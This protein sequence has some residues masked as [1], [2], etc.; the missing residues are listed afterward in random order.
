MTTTAEW[1][2]WVRDLPATVRGP[3][4][5]ILFALASRADSTGESHS[6]VADLCRISGLG[7]T[8]V[9]TAMRE[10]EAMGV[11]K[12]NRSKGGRTNRYRL[13]QTEPVVSR[14]VVRQPVASRPKTGRLATLDR[15][16]DDPRPVASR[17]LSRQE[18]NKKQNKK[19]AREDEQPTEH[20]SWS[21]INAVLM[22]GGFSFSFA[23]P[24]DK[25]AELM[26][27]LRDVCI[28][29]RE[30]DLEEWQRA[31]ILVHEYGLAACKHHAG[32]IR[33][34]VADRPVNYLQAILKEDATSLHGDAWKLKWQQ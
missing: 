34:P 18:A 16:G 17:P 5:A 15:S 19:L 6:G 3:A 13:V 10:L 22:P 8:A 21:D 23:T 20:P 1:V 32:K 29:R 31:D 2:W 26:V 4:R 27:I 7:R 9:K 30:C 24:P 28:E 12:V 14:P 33:G 11:V 25:L